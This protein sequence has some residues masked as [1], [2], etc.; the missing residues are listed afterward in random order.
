MV[1]KPKTRQ[2]A[3]ALAFTSVVAPIS[4]LHKFYLNQPTWGVIYLVL[5]LFT[6]IPRIASAIE[7]FW[8]LTQA[9]DDFEQ[10]FNLGSTQIAS[11]SAVSKAVTPAVD[12]SHISAIAEAVRQLDQLRQD[13]LISE[14]EFEQKRRQL[15]DTMT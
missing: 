4:G 14:Y 12:P 1:T 3:I 5:S 7:G 15:L 11:S 13:G 8:Y 6:P 9:S 2:V 10:N